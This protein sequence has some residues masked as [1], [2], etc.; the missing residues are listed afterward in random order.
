MITR[1]DCIVDSLESLHTL[2]SR[3]HPSFTS[4][5]RQHLV[6]SVPKESVWAV[7]VFGARLPVVPDKASVEVGSCVVSTGE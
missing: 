4:L 6:S 1:H 2:F 7:S 3:L 5:K